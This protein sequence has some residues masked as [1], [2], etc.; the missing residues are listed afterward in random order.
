MSLF[1]KIFSFSLLILFIALS[2]LFL[3]LLQKEQSAIEQRLRTDVENRVA[4]YDDLLHQSTLSQKQLD[5]FAD[6]LFANPAIKSVEINDFLNKRI[7]YRENSL[8]HE[9]VPDWFRGSIGFNLEAI[10]TYT[11][12]SKQENLSITVALNAGRFYAPLYEKLLWYLQLGGGVSFLFALLFAAGLRSFVNPLNEIRKQVVFLKENKFYEAPKLPKSSDLKEISAMLNAVAV[13]LKEK[14]SKDTELLNKYYNVIYNDDETGLNNR[15]YFMMNLVSE[16]ENNASDASGLVCFVKISNYDLLHNEHG[17][18]RVMHALKQFVQILEKMPL[19]YTVLAR[20]KPD[21]FA[22]I[23][24]EQEFEDSKHKIKRYYNQLQMVLDNHF[25]RTADVAVAASEFYRGESVKNVLSRVD[26]SLNEAMMK[27]SE[28]R[29]AF[30]DTGRKALSKEE[31]IALVDYAF[32]KD[33]FALEMRPIQDMK[34]GKNNFLKAVINLKD[35]KGNSYTKSE[36][37]SI[38]YEKNLVADFDKHVLQSVIRKYKLLNHPIRIMISISKEF[39]KSLEHVRWLADEL[40]QLGGNDNLK[41]CLSI[42]DS[43]AEKEEESLK[44]FS[45]LVHKFHH[46]LAIDGFT[47]NHQKIDYIQRIK[48]K[49][50]VVGQEYVESLYE[51][52]KTRVK[53]LNFIVDKLGAKIIVTYIDRPETIAGLKELEVD[54]LISSNYRGEY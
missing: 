19:E 38:L 1:K 11:E 54:Y 8:P 6:K 16:L 47:L 45:D 46:S 43:V 4:K 12:N 33:G 40:E 35:E 22:Y 42:K 23:L 49:Y 27:N 30:A 21:T 53:A 14:F 18:R 13:R 3:L 15:N 5:L 2:A 7:Y 44:R 37:L 48:P 17:F 36:F 20:I 51:E 9:S 29:I 34:S 32:N 26:T 50:I 52:E 39:I 24:A 41:F 28:E 25:E 10:N 31:R